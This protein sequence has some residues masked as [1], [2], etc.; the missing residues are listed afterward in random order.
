[1]D[2]ILVV[3]KPKG[4]TSFDVIRQ[5]RKLTGLK[6][7]GH[8]GTLDPEASGVLPLCIGKATGCSGFLTEKDKS[9]IAEMTL[10]S[11]TDTQDHTG[12]VLEISDVRVCKEQV[13]QVLGE[14][15]GQQYQKPPIYSAIKVQGQ[16][17]YELAR[18]GREPEVELVPRKI[19]IYSIDDVKFVESDGFVDKVSFRVD[20]SK[21]TYIRTLCNDIGERLGC[22][23]HMSALTRIRSGDF[24]IE[25][26]YTLEEIKQLYNTNELEEKLIPCDFIFHEYD[27]INLNDDNIRRYLNGIPIKLYKLP[28]SALKDRRAGDFVR[29]YSE[30]DEFIGLSQVAEDDY[31]LLLKPYKLFIRR[32]EK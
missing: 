4:I 10:G 15:M 11:K 22:L 9:Y 2:G 17:L 21:G 5:I 27:R 13:L 23:A 30:N 6:K 18:E 31:G 12:L 7:I 29:I 20:C 3:N 8:T 24:S 19:I 26:S 32:D 16:K 25:K 14:F 28:K 1:M